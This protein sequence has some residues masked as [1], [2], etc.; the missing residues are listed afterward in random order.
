MGLFPFSGTVTAITP[1]SILYHPLKIFI[2][3]SQRETK[4]NL[5]EIEAHEENTSGHHPCN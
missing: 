4:A 3:W 2:M 5:K 1:T